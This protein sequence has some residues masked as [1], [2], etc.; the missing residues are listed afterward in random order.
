MRQLPV[1]VLLGSSLFACARNSGTNVD[2]A[3]SAVDSSDSVESEGNLMMASVDGAD[4]SGLTALTGDQV[5]AHIAANAPARFT[6]AGCATATASGS[7]VTLTLNDC[8]GPRG[9]VHVTGELDLT[10]SVSLTGAISVHGAATNLMVNRATLDVDSDA[11]Y[12][13][14]GTTHTLDVQTQGSGVGPLGND[15]EHTGQYTIT[16]D[17]GSQCHSIAGH[18]STELS[19]GTASAT[20]SND[21]NLMRCAGGCPTGTV[22]HHFLG[23][24]S[25]TITFDG[26]ATAQW[27]TSGGK[28]GTVNLSCQ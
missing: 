19:S 20:R 11:I 15:V 2:S 22:T 4:M 13:V 21:V 28:S 17:T 3:E 27:S 8:T 14:N 12:A 6:P 24:A 7:N 16:W 18:W 5:A 10:A 23:G 25:L 26:T 9:L 1:F